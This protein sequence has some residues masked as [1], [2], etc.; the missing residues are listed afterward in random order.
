MIHYGYLMKQLQSCEDTFWESIAFCDGHLWWAI[1][2]SL[3]RQE[4]HIGKIKKGIE[5]SHQSMIWRLTLIPAKQGVK[6]TYLNDIIFAEFR[7]WKKAGT[8]P[9][10]ALFLS[11]VSG[12]GHR[13]NQSWNQSDNFHKCNRYIFLHLRRKM[14]YKESLDL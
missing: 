10:S 1:E 11:K 4:D 6:W 14:S 12:Q 3:K 7:Y 8:I 5:P 13:Y 2:K 9:E